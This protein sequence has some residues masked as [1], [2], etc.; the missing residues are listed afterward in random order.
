MNAGMGAGKQLH[1]KKGW[2]TSG[3]ITAN[4]G[5]ANGSQGQVSLQA[6]FQHDPDAYTVAF[7]TNN[8]VGNGVQV[9]ALLII[10]VEGSSVTRVIDVDAGA[11]ITIVGQALNVIAY[12]ASPPFSQ[13]GTITYDVYIQCSKGTRG[14]FTNPP[15]LTALNPAANNM[16][17]FDIPGGGGTIEVP[18]PTGPSSQ[19]A[20]AVSV[21]VAIS[22]FPNVVP[23]D[24]VQVQMF[25]NGNVIMAYD[26]RDMQ[27]APLAPGTQFLQLA[28]HNAFGVIATVTFGIDG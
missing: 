13:I 5:G 1:P 7:A 8:A 12:D 27:W 19:L 28:N 15:R 24:S 4:A 23:D 6:N 9:R 2:S 11:S 16:P 10:S 25:N 21:N 14:T 17:V 18:I 26:P 20:G 3:K 22:G